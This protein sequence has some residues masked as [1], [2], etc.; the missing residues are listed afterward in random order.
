MPKAL[1]K[2]SFQPSHSFDYGIKSVPDTPEVLLLL[3]LCAN[4]A[5][6]LEGTKELVAK[7]PEQKM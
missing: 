4:S 1:S 2:T 5:Q 7:G 3:V 6:C